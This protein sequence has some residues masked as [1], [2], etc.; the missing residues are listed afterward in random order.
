MR[1]YVI[2]DIHGQLELLKAAHRRIAEDRERTGDTTSPVIHL[3]DLTDRGPDSCGVIEFLLSGRREGQN[4]PVIKGNHDRMFMGFLGDAAYHDPGLTRELSW[5]H[6]R[7]GGQTTMASY[8][9]DV[10]DA[11]DAQTVRQRALAK[12]PERHIEFMQGLPLSAQRGGCL[13]VH[14]GIRP[15][16]AL[17][18]QSE[19]D[20][21]WIRADFL[22]D[23]RDHGFLVV[24]GHTALEA[25]QLYGNRLNLDSGAGYGRALTAAVIEDRAV[26]VLEDDGRR[27][28]T[29]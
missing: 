8:G 16:V 27:A 10:S 11:D 5:L 15:G 2:G 6:P 26:F 23:A 29:P 12:V 20:L 19:D 1:S 14:A 24:H 21:L 18:D 25:P 28:L 13:F 9:V 22:N 7:L 4:W 3:G 17:S